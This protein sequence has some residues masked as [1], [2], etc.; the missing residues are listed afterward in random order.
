M[1]RQDQFLDVIDRD[2]AE[3]R[4]HAAM[5][6]SPR[7]SESIALDA[8]LGRVLSATVMS[9][10][11]VP[12]FD[13]SNFD[14]YVVRAEDTVGATEL[15]PRSI[16]LLPE[17]IEAGHIPAT[18][19]Q[20]GEALVIATG[21]M[22]P[23]GADAVIMVESAEEA[24]GCVL[25]S[26]SVSAG[27]GISFAG[28]DISVGEV[29][30]RA[31][32]ILTSRET[33]VL[34]AIGETEVEVF[35]KPSVAIFSTGN[36]IIAP[37][38]PPR[39]AA[40]YDSNS[41]VLADAVLE[42]GGDP[43]FGGIIRDDACSLRDAVT[44][45]LADFDMVL[46]SGGTSKGE[47]D[48]CYRVVRELQN[49]GI[50]V[51]G[52]ALKPG[53]PLCI[54]VTA[55]IPVIVL[56]GFPTSAIFTFHEF[57][58][59]VIRRLAGRS[60]APTETVTAEL[61]VQVNSEVGRTEYLL[62]ALIPSS[63]G[64]RAFPMGKGSGSVT[65][66]SRADGFIAIPRH[67]EILAAGEQVQI[68]LQG[69]GLQLAELVVIGSHCMGLDFLLTELQRRGITSKLLTL[70]STAGLMAAKRDECDLAGIHLLDP[71]SGQYNT[72]WITDT[73]DLLPG[74]RRAQGIIFRRG[75]SRFEGRSVPQLAEILRT[76]HGVRM[77][78]RN[79][80]SGTRILIDRLLAG[81]RPAGYAIQ[82]GNHAAVVAAIAQHRADWG[83]AIAHAAETAE[84]ASVPLQ[85]EQFDF[86]IPRA[87]QHR[88]AVRAFCELLKNP[89]IQTRLKQLGL[90]PVR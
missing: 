86:V 6:L 7:G 44:R 82:P 14:G 72:P 20:S 62:A 28:T 48:L 53:K 63:Q 70:G 73:L 33:G 83:I 55:G 65:T 39:A 54:A 3:R 52:V 67:T 79:A 75:D 37:G 51:H 64:L 41:R 18:D 38:D 40:V 43:W 29:V 4:F 1:A 21:G 26:R 11:D 50:V 77:V 2:E 22:V 9:R 17:R 74:Y 59:P 78:N 19:V 5:D 89:E 45:A 88:P 69:K 12:A 90:S 87:R 15:Q 81:V 46:L 13:R 71:G 27:T 35:R 25:V 80:G 84:L 85:D 23:R 58:A 34:A 8:A 49:P 36:E 56:P 31:G 61:A 57:V 66:F 68:Q 10:I 76:N 32:T 24:S 47:G 42:A 30:L 16:R 60:P